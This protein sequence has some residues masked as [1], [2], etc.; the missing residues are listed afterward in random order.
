MVGQMMALEQETKWFEDNR[1]ELVK[2]YFGKF[3]V[4]KGN[5]VQGSYDSA[6]SA[7]EAAVRSNPLDGFLIKQV[8]PTEPVEKMPAVWLGALRA[9]A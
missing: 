8:L 7:Y 5:E 1:A 3:L 9:T 2:S 4:I 6:Q